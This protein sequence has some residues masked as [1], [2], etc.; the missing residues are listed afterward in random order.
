MEGLRVAAAAGSSTAEATA[1]IRIIDIR[2]ENR[3][4]G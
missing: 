4:T 2:V 3:W 1:R